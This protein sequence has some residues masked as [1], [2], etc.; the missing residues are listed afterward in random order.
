MRNELLAQILPFFPVH[1]ELSSIDSRSDVVDSVY[2]QV[3]ASFG[4]VIFA[5]TEIYQ[6]NS[7]AIVQNKF[8]VS[9]EHFDLLSGGS[10]MGARE[11]VSTSLV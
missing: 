2:M 3:T 8:T 9:M 11:I 4:Q 10:S 7:S 6:C 1:V 5:Q